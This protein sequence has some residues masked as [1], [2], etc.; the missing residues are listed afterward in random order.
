MA[1]E[2]YT[3]PLHKDA[4]GNKA[5]QYGNVVPAQNSLPSL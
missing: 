4:S 1:L 3:S 5:L 2:Q